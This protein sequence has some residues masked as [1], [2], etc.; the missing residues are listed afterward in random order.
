MLALIA[1]IIPKD[2]IILEKRR[3]ADVKRSALAQLRSALRDNDE[4]AGVQAAGHV[5][6]V[7]DR[8]QYLLEV[9]CRPPRHRHGRLLYCWLDAAVT[10]PVT[11]DWWA[12]G[13]KHLDK[14]L[15]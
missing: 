2:S 9:F 13:K 7:F 4:S 1:A 11:Q 5:L 14:W 15:A 6:S 12:S 10:G 3:A 8:R